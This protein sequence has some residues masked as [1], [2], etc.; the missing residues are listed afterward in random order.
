M[1]KPKCEICKKRNEI[2]KTFKL[3]SKCFELTSP[4]TQKKIV[5]SF[6]PGQDMG[7]CDPSTDFLRALSEAK[8]E[9]FL[10][11]YGTKTPDQSVR[12]QSG[13][14]IEIDNSVKWLDPVD[15]EE[16]AGR[17]KRVYWE[18]QEITVSFFKNEYPKMAK[19]PGAIVLIR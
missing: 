4:A 17:V 12:D 9:V 15:G 14:A 11:L 6:L 1:Q 16:L 7:Y 3:C 13:R 2:R 19:I 5:D 8:T 18:T 10:V